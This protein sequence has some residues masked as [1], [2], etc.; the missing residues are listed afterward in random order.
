M[1]IAQYFDVPSRRAFLDDSPEAS[2]L[3]RRAP[4]SIGAENRLL[5]HLPPP[6]LSRLAVYLEPVDLGRKDVLF[7]AHEP[8]TSAY[9]PLTAVVSYVARLEAGQ[10][11][12][13]GITGRDGIAGTAVL[14]GL[15]TMTCDGIVQVRGRALRIAADTLRREVLA[16]PALGTAIGQYMHVLLARSMATSACNMFHAVEQRCIRWLLTLHDLLQHDDL[17]LTHELIAGLLGV[18]RP[19]ITLVLRALHKRGLI[20]ERRACVLIKDRPGLQAAC[21]ECYAV[22]RREQQRVLGY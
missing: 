12:E 5:A 22:I 3:L 11:L 20:D 9:F 15:T 16:D 18:H 6:T 17:P 13:V 2:G 10:T 1:R 14:P 8:L 4:E 21:C 7:R 19:T